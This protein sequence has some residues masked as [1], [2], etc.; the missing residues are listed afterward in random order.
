VGARTL[1]GRSGGGL[2]LWWFVHVHLGDT[3]MKYR[4]MDHPGIILAPL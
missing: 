1:N 2:W 4:E 3:A